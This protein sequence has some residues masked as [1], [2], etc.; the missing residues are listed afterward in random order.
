M[1]LLTA[2]MS[3]PKRIQGCYISE[4]EIKRLVDFLKDQD[5]PHYTVGFDRAGEESSTSVFD[6]GS[7][8]RDQLFNEARTI[9]VESKKAS[10][11][12]L[13]RRLRVGYA[14]AA[15][16]LDELEEAGV[17]GPADGAKPRDVL[18]DALDLDTIER[19][20]KEEDDEIPE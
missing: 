1:L 17:V 8:G 3:K 11:S 5:A 2:D 19:S 20:S 12:F 18:L 14:R 16:L 13:Q 15:R 4:E 6:E 10:A 9:I 7:S